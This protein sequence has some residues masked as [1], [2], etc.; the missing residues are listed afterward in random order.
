MKTKNN[1]AISIGI[2]AILA[3]SV[4]V[5]LSMSGTVYASP[6]TTNYVNATSGNDSWSG[7]ATHPWKTITHAVNTVPVGASPADPNIINVTAGLYDNT[8][9]GEIFAITFNNSNISLIGAGNA[10]TTIDGEGAAT[11]LD[12]N[13]TGITVAGFN[14]TNATNN[15]IYADVGGFIIL[16]NLFCNVSDGVHVDIDDTNRTTDF[17]FDDVLIEGNI[18]NISD[19]GVY[20]DLNL[21]FNDTQTG[22]SATIG[23]MEIWDNIFDMGATDGVDIRL[24]VTNVST[25]TVSIGDV[26]ISSTNVF[27]DGDRGVY[28]DGGLEDFT[29]TTVTVG[30]FM[31]N[32][33][34]FEGQVNYAVYVD[35][36]YYS[37]NWHGATTATFGDLEINGN[38]ISSNEP[39][40][41]GIYVNEYGYWAH[42]YDDVVVTAGNITMDDN[43]P[44][45]VEDNAIYFEY[46]ETGYHLYDNASVTLGD[47]SIQGNT[48]LAGYDG[49]YLSYEYTGNYMHDASQVTTGEVHIGG[50]G[51]GEDNTID[52]GS[53]AIGIGYEDV[54]YGMYQGD[55]PCQARLVMGDIYVQN[56][57]ISGDSDGLELDYGD[58][59]G[60]CSSMDDDAYAELPDYVITGNTFNV[61]G[62]GIYLDTDSIPYDINDDSTCDFGG[63]LIDDNTFNDQDV[64]MGY[65]IYFEYYEFCDDNNDNSTTLVGDVTISNNEFY[66]LQDDAVYIYYYDV[67]YDMDDNAIL[68]VG[69]LVIADNTVDGTGSD[70][71]RVDYDSVE[72]EYNSTVTLGNLDITGN[73]VSGVTE[74][75]I[76]VYYKLDADDTSTMTISRALIQDNTLDG[77]SD[78]GIYVYMLKDRETGATI[79]LGDPIIDDN[80]IENWA[81]GIKLEDVENATITRNMIVNNTGGATGV[82]LPEGS[83]YS[84]IHTNCF[85]NN[86]PQA[87]DNG[88]GNDWTG[89]FWLDYIPPGPYNISGTANNTDN[90]PLDVC[91]L[92]QEPPAPAQVPALTPIGMIALVGL[93][94]VVLAVATLRRKRE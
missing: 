45:D 13:A 32:D 76:H 17:T 85:Y 22:L 21:D 7:N 70:G 37:D 18:F 25:G 44:I 49:I 64:G 33:N 23:K 57:D 73:D 29:D 42:L 89:N 53:Y 38:D 31:V 3:I 79:T 41:D 12:I 47:L 58:I 86:T 66:D 93:L 28:F 5:V 8:T 84:V 51:V 24:Y 10:T 72:S 19:D 62:D 56:N 94:S 61:S 88:T 60:I 36:Y 48:I 16:N 59:E 43:D 30:D 15:G 39:G 81:T 74:D 80:T 90:N 65:G 9:N 52:A 87:M 71:L 46:Y 1:K 82:H 92:G 2:T 91:P 68:E 11:I 78:N 54:A 4:F 34:T 75:G 50:T 69:D 20:I 77:S 63:A 40:S 27:S 55:I 6:G 67:G 83:N 26:D 14:I 35:D